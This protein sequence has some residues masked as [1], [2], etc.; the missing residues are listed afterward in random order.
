MEW[1]VAFCSLGLPAGFLLLWR[2]PLCRSR[3]PCGH[4]A[5]SLI[6]PARNEEANLPGLLGSICESECQ[7]AE[8]L[9]VDDAST[10]R[11]AR[12]AQEYGA[13]VI[14]SHP[15]PPHWTGKNWSCHQGAHQANADVLL[16]LDADTW[17]SPNGYEQLANVYCDSGDG[18]VAISV[19]PYHVVQK[20]Y[21]ELSLF[22]NLLMAMGAGG[23]GW[24]SGPRLF[25][26]SLII[27]RDLYR[28][29]EGH[30]GVS[31]SIL[32]NLALSFRLKDVGG[33]CVCFG[34]R[35]VLNV[36]MF[37]HGIAQL[38]EGWTKAFADGAVA[39][40]AAIVTVAVLWLTALST[41]FFALLFASAIARLEFGILYLAFVLQLRFFARQIGNFSAL[42]CLLY[43][44]PLFFYF[45]LFGHALYRKVFHRKVNWR[46]R[47][48]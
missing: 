16:F 25:G 11:T 26:Q 35:G 29:S 33:R 13:T 12:V 31:K 37:P 45:S 36:R 23:F 43:P 39:S 4:E 47:T 18:N 28:A 8:V 10:D 24:L 1:I 32:E 14:A 20:A 27:S 3:V 42:T 48:L 22:F 38:C 15:L 41:S 34:G 6:V 30:Q 44:L 17:F 46:G 40:G 5:I 7:P 19:L 9:V 21:E 2:V